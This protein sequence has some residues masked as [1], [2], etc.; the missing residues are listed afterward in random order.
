MSGI[1]ARMTFVATVKNWA[2]ELGYPVID[3]D[4]DDAPA[5]DRYL[6]LTHVEDFHDNPEEGITTVLFDLALFHTFEESG[7]TNTSIIALQD[8]KVLQKKIKSLG[9][10]EKFTY[11]A[12][13]S[14]APRKS[15]QYEVELHES[16]GN[17]A[18]KRTNSHISITVE[19]ITTDR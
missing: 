13:S 3:K 2:V 1:D 16:S 15:G 11:D 7:T 14:V 18:R 9:N 12:D 5:N 8:L 10:Q 4:L 19:L 17:L 6:Q